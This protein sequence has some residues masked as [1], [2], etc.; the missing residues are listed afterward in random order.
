MLVQLLTSIKFCILYSM[1]TINQIQHF[2][3]VQ[4]SRSVC[5][6]LC[7]LL[8]R[9]CL[10]FLASGVLVI[11]YFFLL[12]TVLNSNGPLWC[13]VMTIFGKIWYNFDL[14]KN[15]FTHKSH[16]WCYKMVTNQRPSFSHT[17][18]PPLFVLKCDHGGDYATLILLC[19]RTADIVAINGWR[20]K[21]RTE[22]GG[23]GV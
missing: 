14:L 13:L 9:D 6:I 1:L 19:A 10:L 22:G 18:A 11:F 20:K 21:D 2:F 17:F 8:K 5:R 3:I 23:G 12:V 16:L 15:Y 4:V 7:L